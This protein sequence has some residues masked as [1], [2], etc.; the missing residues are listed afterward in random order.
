M[1]DSTQDKQQRRRAIR[2]RVV[3]LTIVAAVVTNV[4]MRIRGYA[5]PG[6]SPVRCSQGHLFETMWVEGASFTS[7][8]LGPTTRF[9]RCPVGRHWAIVHP[10]KPADLT[11]EDRAAL[12]A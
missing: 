9:M 8:R 3:F 7:L 11:D 10:V 6:R 4:V 5:I 2:R 12:A 1:T